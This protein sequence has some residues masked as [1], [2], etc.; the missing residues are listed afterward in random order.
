M[1]PAGA[2]GNLRG[3]SAAGPLQKHRHDL[4]HEDHGPK[5]GVG[6]TRAIQIMLAIWIVATFALVAHAVWDGLRAGPATSQH[7]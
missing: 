4:G 6:T 5:I 1:T 3:M 2:W 7:N